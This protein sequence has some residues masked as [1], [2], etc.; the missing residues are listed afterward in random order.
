[1][2]LRTDKCSERGHAEFSISYDSG[3]IVNEDAIWLISYLENAVISGTVF[4]VGET[5]QIGWMVNE[6]AK[7]ADGLTL[8]EPDFSGVPITWRKSVDTT[9][10]H[11]RLQ[12]SVAESVALGVQMPSICESAIVCERFPDSKQLLL[13]RDEPQGNDS[14][15]FL[16]CSDSSHDHNN[17]KV[18]RRISLY[19]AVTKRRDVVEYIALPS[20]IR[21]VTGSPPQI[22]LKDQ[23]LQIVADSYLDRLYH[24]T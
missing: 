23:V 8:L 19:E 3:Q 9:L 2:I 17:P 7:Q 20:G 14:G 22:S 13:T 24:K 18:L 16:G 15:W 10:A 21:I 6:I 12:K 1:M 4:R 5:I 11:L